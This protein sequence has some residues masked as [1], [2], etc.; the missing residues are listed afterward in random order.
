MTD[1]RELQEKYLELQ[2]ISNQINQIQ[3]QAQLLDNQLSELDSVNLG[4]SDFGEIEKGTEILVPLSSGIYAKAELKDNKDLVVN[5]GS[6]VFI[7]KDIPN[8][9]KII[10]AQLDEIRKLR[11]Q[12]VTDI[13]RLIIRAGAIEEEI[14]RISSNKK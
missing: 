1:K 14:S 11:E 7:R 9:K 13:K 10:N 4:L 12:M 6:N 2:L 8:T 5:V 3:K